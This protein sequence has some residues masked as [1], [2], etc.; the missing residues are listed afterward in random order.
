MGV[1]VEYHLPDFL[2]VG[3]E[4]GR[5]VP[6]LIP[7]LA[8]EAGRLSYV[9]APCAG[10]PPENHLSNFLNVGSESGRCVPLLIPPPG[11]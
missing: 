2:S 11:D 7:H 8:T 10:V 6:L 5:C 9:V 4:S 3:S 1:A